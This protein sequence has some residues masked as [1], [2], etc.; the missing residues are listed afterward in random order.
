MYIKMNK[1]AEFKMLKQVNPLFVNSGIPMEIFERI[2]E[3]YENKDMGRDGFIVLWLT[4]VKADISEILDELGINFDKVDIPDDNLYP[5]D[6]KNKEHP[7]T[8]ENPWNSYYIILPDCRG[9]I[10]VIY[11][12]IKYEE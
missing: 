3:I 1:R 2:E 8:K 7:L 10:Y 6:I 5:I 12:T 11:P 4:T 9:K